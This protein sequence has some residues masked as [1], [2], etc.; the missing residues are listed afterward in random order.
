[1]NNRDRQLLSDRQ[2]R[3]TEQY[4]QRA[5]R[6]LADFTTENRAEERLQNILGLADKLQHL[7]LTPDQWERYWAIVELGQQK[8]AELVPS[9]RVSTAEHSESELSGRELGA[10]VII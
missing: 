9:I 8:L 10:G 7:S 6:Y 5:K 2:Q 4:L 3:A 1:V